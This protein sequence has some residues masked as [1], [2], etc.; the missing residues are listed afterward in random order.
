LTLSI[1]DAARQCPD[2]V[3]LVTQERTLTFRQVAQRVERT[4]RWLGSAGVEAGQERPFPFEATSTLPLPIF[5]IIIVIIVIVVV[6]VIIII[7]VI[8][9]VIVVVLECTS[10]HA[11]VASS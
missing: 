1:L 8:I 11:L 2:A 10:T 5:I 7:I 6:I 3:C 9:I 4:V